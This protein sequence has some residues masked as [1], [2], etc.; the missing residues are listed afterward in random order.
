MVELLRIMID[1]EGLDQETTLQIFYDTFSYKNHT[2]LE[3]PYK[4]E[5]PNFRKLLPRHLELIYINISFL[6]KKDLQ[7]T[8]LIKKNKKIHGQADFNIICFFVVLQ[9]FYLIFI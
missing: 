6:A 1:E 4:M 3:E 9:H 8:S 7:K 5:F 2:V